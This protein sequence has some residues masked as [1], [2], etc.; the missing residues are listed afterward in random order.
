MPR[1]TSEI[2]RQAR[3]RIA[4]PSKWCQGDYAVD[5][6][7]EG[8]FYEG[9]TACRWCAKGSLYLEMCKLDLMGKQRSPCSL[10][11]AVS[12]HLYGKYVTTINDDIGHETVMQLYDA[13]IAAAEKEEAMAP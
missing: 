12:Q 8:T 10:L 13:A 4:D 11:E 1:K 2:L 5:A 3:A 7:G 9:H 6:N